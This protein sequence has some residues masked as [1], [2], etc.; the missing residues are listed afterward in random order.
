MRFE[1]LEIELVSDGGVRVDAGGPFGLV[2]RAL[3]ESIFEPDENNTLPMVL[4]CLLVRSRGKTI[5]IDTGLGDK[6][7]PAEVDRWKLSRPEGGLIES[8][9]SHGVRPDDVDIVLNTHLHA[10]HCGGNTRFEGDALVPVFPRAEY[11][12]QRMEWAEAYHPDARTQGTYLADNFAPLMPL[13]RLRLLHGDTLVTDQVSCVVTP[14]HT[15]AHQSIVLRAGEW[16]GLY[17]ADMATYAVHMSRTAWLTAY[18]V[19]P[20]ENVAT[21]RRWQ[22][23]AIEHDAW[24]FFEHDPVTQ[25]ARLTEDGGRL[26][27]EK[28]ETS[29]QVSASLPTPRPPRG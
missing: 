21:K 12:V 26:R 6:L 9:A 2:P 17:V 25:I 1:D 18:D 8:L 28:V 29:V 16:R 22:L 5:L 11:W 23:W 13:G 19:Q 7:S 27:I 24:L 14:G 20:L 10:D 3:Y 4:T 15:R